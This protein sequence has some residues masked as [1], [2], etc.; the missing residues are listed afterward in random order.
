[1]TRLG[2]GGAGDEGLKRLGAAK[3]APVA[4]L[5]LGASKVACFIMTPDGV[6]RADQTIRVAHA[7]HVQSRGVKGGV[8]VDMDEAAQAIAHAVQRAERDCE[9]PV[10]SV[11]VTTAIGQPKGHRIAAEVSLGARPIRDADLG[12][13]IASAMGQA[14]YPGRR[15]IHL[16]PIRWS[17]DGAHGVRDP[18]GLTGKVLGLELLVVTIAETA[19]AA[20]AHCLAL[21]HLDLEGVVASP[22]MSALS[23]LEEDEKDLGCACIDM[24]AGSTTAA[25]FAGGSLVHVDG[26]PVGG[27]H[28]TADIARG[29]STSLNGAERI[30]TMHGSCMASAHEDGEKIEAPP[31]G[32]DPGAGAI[33]V[34]RGIV[35]NIIAPRVEETLELVRDRL[36][37]S[38]APFEPGAGVVLTGGASQLVG[39]RELA[40][41]VFDRP[42]RLARPIRSPHLADAASGPAFCAASGVLVRAAYGPREAVS[43]RKLMSA[44]PGAAAAQA[45]AGAFTRIAGWLRD[46]L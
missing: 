4:A 6:R 15:A 40:T 17:V 37:Q 2:S 34:D 45:Q 1:M 44:R 3:P 14:R 43:A 33:V 42:V 16:L 30:K 24:G 31:R 7:G 22:F 32:D 10:S 29:L 20:L 13:A 35:K 18:R 19:F 12:R 5:D 25:V 23:A 9:T 46:N 27:H 41:R 11:V 21:A 38:G 28:V 26:V 8:L 39:V 36:K